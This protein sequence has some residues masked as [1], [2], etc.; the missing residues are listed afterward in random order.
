MKYIIT[1]VLIIL[2]FSVPILPQEKNN[3]IPSPSES[4]INKLNDF[5]YLNKGDLNNFNEEEL[6]NS[7]SGNNKLLQK[8]KNLENKFNVLGYQMIKIQGLRAV[9]PYLVRDFYK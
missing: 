6:F 2:F 7:Y 8:L 3:I 1:L 4:L 9:K 5:Y